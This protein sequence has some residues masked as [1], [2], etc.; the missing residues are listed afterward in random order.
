MNYWLTVPNSFHLLRNTVSFKDQMT[1]A[2][3]SY[4]RVSKDFTGWIFKIFSLYIK[5]NNTYTK[6]VS[7]SQLGLWSCKE[8]NTENP[9]STRS[10]KALPVWN[11][12][13]RCKT[14]KAQSQDLA[15][16]ELFSCLCSLHVGLVSIFFLF[17]FSTRILL[18][19]ND[20]SV[21]PWTL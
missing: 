12:L 16:G 20:T 8:Q 9:D 18:S 6:L 1:I 21:Y 3:Y 5:V 17:W 10:L 11:A 14:L 2:E 13:Q 15:K 4:K 19:A 7:Q